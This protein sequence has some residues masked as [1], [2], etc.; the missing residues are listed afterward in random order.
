MPGHVDIIQA[1]LVDT[2]AATTAGAFALA[3]N[4]LYTTEAWRLF[5]DRLTPR[6]LLTFTRW[7]DL[8]YPAEVYRLVSL[9]STA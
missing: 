9:A 6:G 1:S 7:Y 2:W 3:E 4:S 8:Q 5:L